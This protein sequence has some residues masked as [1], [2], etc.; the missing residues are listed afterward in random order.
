MGINQRIALA[1]AVLILDLVVFFLPLSA[2]FLAYILIF[3]PP[4]FRQFLEKS[5]HS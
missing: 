5:N 3:N 2:L 1:V 4:W